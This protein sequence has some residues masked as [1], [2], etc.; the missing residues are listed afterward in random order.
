MAIRTIGIREKDYS[1]ETARE[2]DLSVKKLIDESYE[3]AK[4]ILTERR[5]VLD[6]GASLLFEKET[7]TPEDFAP[8]IQA[9]DRSTPDI[10]KEPAG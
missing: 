10:L 6:Q 9:K 7:L 3:R 1:E 4:T 5:S 8:L 2:I